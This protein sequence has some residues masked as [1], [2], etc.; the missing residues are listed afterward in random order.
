[1]T[2]NPAKAGRPL[3][4]KQVQSLNSS[5]VGAAIKW[6]S[7]AQT[8]IFKK[9]GG[10]L[11]DKFLRGAEVGILTTT[12][13]KS[14]EKRDSPLLFLQE[15][16]RIIL[17]AS[18]GGRATNPMWYLNLKANPNIAFQTKREVLTLVARDAT[19]AE[20]DEYWPKLDAMYAD[21]VNYRS[22]TDRQIPIVLCDPA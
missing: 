4:P 10:R 6:M 14:G 21:F 20:R 2:D 3:S 18:Q 9:T 16:R 19:E 7:K 11:G 12:G 5:G 8:W 22:Y 15:G 1:M 13:R 17:V